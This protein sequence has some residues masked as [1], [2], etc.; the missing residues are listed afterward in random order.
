MS[1]TPFHAPEH[2]HSHCMESA[3]ADAEN[4]CNSIGVRLTRQRRRVLE[5]VW[6]SHSPI[7]AYEILDR[8]AADGGRPAPMTIYRALDFLQA[9]GLVHRIAS[10]NAFI[11]CTHPG[12][13]HGNQFLICRQ[14]KSVAELIDPRLDQAI[15]QSADEMGFQIEHQSVELE[16]ICRHCQPEGG[17]V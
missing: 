4:L 12:S 1:D 5:I 2:D 17:A 8:L 3:L 11:G 10:L 9:H 13:R 16:G 15:N 7:G 14:C 6:E